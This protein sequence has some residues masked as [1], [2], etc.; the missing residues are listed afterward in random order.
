MDDQTATARDDAGWPS[1]FGCRL[2]VATLAAGTLDI[3]Y[4]CIVGLLRERSPMTVLQSVATGWQGGAAFEGGVPSA[5]LGLGTHYGIMLAMAACFGLLSRRVPALRRRPWPTGLIYGL[6]LYAVMYGIVLPL[7]FP[8]IFPRL[9]G[10][11]TV[12]DII[13]HMAVGLIIVRL[14]S[15]PVAA[16]RR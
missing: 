1:G 14:F 4:A 9:S 11:I 10:W 16:R 2:L 6:G 3:V 8:E 7:R 12:T 15:A 5:L 13:V